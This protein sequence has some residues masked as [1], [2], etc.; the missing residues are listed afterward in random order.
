MY[1]I[2]NN[3]FYTSKHTTRKGK[4]G[5]V[6]CSGDK[7]LATQVCR[8]EFD[9]LNP[10]WGGRREPSAQAF[11]LT[12]TSAPYC[13]PP[14]IMW[15]QIHFLKKAQ[16]GQNIY[17]KYITDLHLE[18]KKNLVIKWQITRLNNDARIWIDSSPKTIS[19]NIKKCFIY[20]LLKN[21]NQNHNKV[22]HNTY[23]S[24]WGTTH[25]ILVSV[26][27]HTTHT[28]VCEVP[29]DTYWCLW[30]ITDGTS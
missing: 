26:R 13:V 8:P 18:P 17:V 3:T 14:I 19:K 12:S 7:A 15:T 4:D 9:P 5:E 11:P 22:P 27:F 20:Q 6:N 16:N 25:H 1:F 21:T 30:G 29:H 10:H 28:H 2:K 24:L 23:R